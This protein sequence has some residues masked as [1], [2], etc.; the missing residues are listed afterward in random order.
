MS[1]TTRMPKPARVRLAVDLDCITY[2]RLE[3]LARRAGVEVAD[4]LADLARW[5]GADDTDLRYRPG[6]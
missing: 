3:A 6:R 4:L 5:V 1:G 2:A